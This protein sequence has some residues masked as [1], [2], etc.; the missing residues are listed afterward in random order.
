MDISIFDSLF[1]RAIYLPSLPHRGK[2]VRV[3]SNYHTPGIGR[4]PKKKKKKKKSELIIKL[5]RDGK[6]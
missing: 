1:S 2:R 3:T 6:M 4:D 5:R